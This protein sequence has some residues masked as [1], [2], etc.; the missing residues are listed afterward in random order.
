MRCRPCAWSNLSPMCLVCTDEDEDEDATRDTAAAAANEL[1]FSCA[2][3]RSTAGGGPVAV[4][5]P[6]PVVAVERPGQRSDRQRRA[7]LGFVVH[8]HEH[9]PS[10]GERVA[11]DPDD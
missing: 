5:V 10:A 8:Q 2:R 4:P 11:D 3:P 9:L 6:V 7:P 1:A